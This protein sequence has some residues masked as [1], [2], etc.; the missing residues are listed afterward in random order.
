MHYPQLSQ[1]FSPT[2][3]AAQNKN[4]FLHLIQFIIKKNR[5]LENSDNGLA[6]KG[7]EQAAVYLT[8]ARNKSYQR[9]HVAVC[10]QCKFNHRCSAFM[11][12]R[13]TISLK[14]NEDRPAGI[15]RR[16]IFGHIIYELKE[17]KR[18][19]TDD[20]DPSTAS[21]PAMNKDSIELHPHISEI[22]ATLNGIKRLCSL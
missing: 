5:L 19:V 15:D 13:R 11:E 8:C 12:Y 1:G 22:K 14:K 9:K 18:L 21:L 17:I 4:F 2:G 3:I 20:G 7:N 16:Q 6:M 10:R